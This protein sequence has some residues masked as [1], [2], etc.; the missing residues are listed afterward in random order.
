VNKLQDSAC[1]TISRH[2][3]VKKSEL[4]TQVLEYWDILGLEDRD[5][6][7]KKEI[8]HPVFSF[9]PGELDSS[10]R[11]DGKAREIL[12]CLTT[13]KL[14]P[15]SIDLN[16]FVKTA[17]YGEIRSLL[18]AEQCPVLC[19]SYTGVTCVVSEPDSSVLVHDLHGGLLVYNKRL[20]SHRMLI[21]PLVYWLR[22]RSSGYGTGDENDE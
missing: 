4:R 2:F 9:S 12:T 18:D 17:I 16:R 5:Y 7:T 19:Q 6:E 15:L 8:A 20:G 21:E 1:L 11:W 3:K 10:V 22:M 13:Q 14:P